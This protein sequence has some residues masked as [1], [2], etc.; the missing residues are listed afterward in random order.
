MQQALIVCQRWPGTGASIAHA[1][2]QLSAGSLW[3]VFIL[4]EEAK[5]DQKLSLPWIRDR[6]A[7]W[8]WKTH[9]LPSPTK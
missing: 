2:M 8:T 6:T 4:G 3:Q 9:V 1:L 5:I 7:K